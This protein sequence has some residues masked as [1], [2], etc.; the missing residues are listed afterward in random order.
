MAYIP[1]EICVHPHG[2]LV[3]AGRR[4]LRLSYGFE[5]LPRIGRAIALMREA[6]A[7]AETSR[8]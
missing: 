8:D 7:Y 6:V 4:E 1:G 5:E 2:E 3:E